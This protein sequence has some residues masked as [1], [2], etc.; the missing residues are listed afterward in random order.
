MIA[1]EIRKPMEAWNKVRDC[2]EKGPIYHPLQDWEK[3]ASQAEPGHM[4]K[5]TMGGWR[6]FNAFPILETFIS[7]V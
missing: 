5:G 3:R 1:L 7:S 4:V 6:V 2:R